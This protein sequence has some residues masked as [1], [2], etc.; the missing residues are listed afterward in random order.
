[1]ELRD[2]V[3]GR[4]SVR[5]FRADPVPDALVEELLELAKWAPSA[6]NLQDWFVTS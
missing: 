2:A 4:R 5:S 1:M 3:L 6:G